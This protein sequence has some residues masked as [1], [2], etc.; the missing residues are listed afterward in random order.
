MTPRKCPEQLTHCKNP[1]IGERIAKRQIYNKKISFQ[2][3]RHTEEAQVIGL[4]GTCKVR[5][6]EL[7]DG[8]V[9]ELR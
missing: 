2:D 9:L 8:R 5:R 6:K 1:F 7:E 3:L 4:T